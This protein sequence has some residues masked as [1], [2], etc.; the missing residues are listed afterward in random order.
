VD[1]QDAGVDIK[2]GQAF[3]RQIAQRVTATSQ[4]GVLAGIGGFAGLMAMPTGLREPILVASTDGVGTKLMV[5]QACQQHEGIG[6]DLVAMCVNDILTVGAQPLF[7]LDYLATGRINQQVLLQIIEGILKGCKQADCALLGGETAE[8]PGLYQPQ[9]YDVAGFCVGVVEKEA[10]LNGQQVQAGDRVVALPSS[11]VHSNGYSLVRGIVADR[12]WNWQHTPP[13]WTRS[14]GEE[15]LTPTLI[16]GPQIRSL[17]AAGVDIHAMA[18]IT[19]GGL[20]ENLPRC[21]GPQLSIH[22]QPYSWRIPPVF[23]WL[24]VEGSVDTLEMFRTFNMGIGYVLILPPAALETTFRLLPQAFE[25]GEVVVGTG[26]VLG[27]DQWQ[28]P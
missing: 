17:Q 8:M 10:I 25:I 3:V 20:P 12:G 19:G 5:A 23:Q 18:H 2:A 21:L 7:F 14:L 13:G 1:Y 27:L 4:A 26:E 22:L 11:G 15:L 16:Y 24:Q 6:I 28:M 9:H